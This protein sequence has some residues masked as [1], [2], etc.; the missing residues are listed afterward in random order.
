MAKTSREAFIQISAHI[1]RQGG[2]YSDWYCGITS[3]IEDKLFYDHY[4]PKKY[5]WRISRECENS[6]S[7]RA[8]EKAL[9]D[10]G[11]DGGG[12]RGDEDSIYVYAYLK[13]SDTVP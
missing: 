8:V 13:S 11:C 5:H 7:A 9:L 12:S 2:S 1:A 3:N 10:F 6:E 4:V